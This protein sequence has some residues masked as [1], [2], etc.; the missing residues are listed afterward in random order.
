M[1][2]RGSQTGDPTLVEYDFGGGHVVAFAQPYDFAWANDQ[3][4]ARILENAVPYAVNFFTD[5]PWLSESP[6]SG[7]LAAG[8]DAT[9]AVTIGDPG[10]SPGEHRAQVVFVTSTPKP[11]FVTVDVVPGRPSGVVGRPVGRDH[12]RPQRGA[13][14]GVGVTLHSQWNGQPLDAS[15]TSGGDGTWTL[16]GPGL[17]T[18]AARDRPRRLRRR[19]PRRDRHAGYDP[20]RRRRG[21]PP[22]RPTWRDRRRRCTSCSS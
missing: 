17:Q 11:R 13:A 10:L 15:A 16:I 4:S 18:P 1:I 6:A 3:D 14:A 2:A 22:G 19:D 5:V 7:S 9:I 21:T 20:D 8:A 12:R